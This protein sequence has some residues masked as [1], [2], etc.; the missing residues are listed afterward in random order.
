MLYRFHCKVA[1]D[2]LML[3]PAGDWVLSA[4]GVAPA[5]K[6]IIQPEAMLA[7]IGA[8]EAA[9]ARDE[10]LQPAARSAQEVAPPPGDSGQPV[11]LRQRAWPLIDM[12]HR[13]YA[14]GESIVWGI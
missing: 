11:S 7:A 13:A 5:A 9:I 8:V 10:S 12:M 4:M 3:G 1:G 6:G 14:A 2:V